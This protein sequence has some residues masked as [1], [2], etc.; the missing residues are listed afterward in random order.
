MSNRIDFYQGVEQS[1]AIPAA[2]GAVVFINGAAS[3][4][5]EVIEIIT[6][7]APEFGSARFRFDKAGYE[8]QHINQFAQLA[9]VGSCVE[10]F[11][12]YDKGEGTSIP[13][14]RRIFIGQIE[15]AEATLEENEDL[16]E[17]VARDYSA[18][19][20]R[21]T[22]SG[23]RIN[24]GDT[25]FEAKGVSLVFNEDGNGNASRFSVLRNGN[26]SRLFSA[27]SNSVYWTCSGVVEYL[28]AEYV[29]P[30]AISMPPVEL[31]DTV[32]DGAVCDE[33]DVEGD[34]LMDALVKV[35]DISGVSFKFVPCENIGSSRISFYR[36][37]QCRRVELDMQIEGEVLNLSKTQIGKIKRASSF[38]PIT[39]R[40]YA[41]GEKK[42]FE[43][44]FELV[45]AWDP[46]L[47]GRTQ[48]EYETSHIDY[49]QVV[50]VYRKWCLNETGEYSTAPYNRGDMFDLS[51][52]DGK[53][54]FLGGQRRFTDSISTDQDGNSYGVYGEI[55]Y[56]SGAN[57]EKFDGACATLSNECG[58][59][60]SGNSLGTD[61]Y[62][63]AIAGLLRFRVTAAVVSDGR[64]MASVAD[65]PVGSVVEVCDYLVNAGGLF[66][67]RKV[68]GGS[69]FY[70][71]RGG[72]D[73]SEK[74]IGALRKSANRVVNTIET[75]DIETPFVRTTIS[76][77]D[78]VVSGT[79]GRDA[80]G[81]IRDG[82]S[83]FWVDRVVMN[84]KRQTTQLKIL[85]KRQFDV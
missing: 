49:P 10:V 11:E 2:T 18:K 25:G 50:D 71:D 60:V 3:E 51:R 70:P 55:S 59:T 68:C 32:M 76:V 15:S 57:W 61:F 36:V 6:D 83:V 62:N 20:E 22:V 84:F 75:I 52:L 58:L 27:D 47:E 16:V 77:G 37:G 63:A 8:A 35:C 45:G 17:I 43:S 1:L 31:I 44:T 14:K 41:M 4:F 46:A 13:E 73:D 21:I 72:I 65:G 38:W 67:Y 5:F 39:H 85:R 19:M 66:E 53:A 42:I 74:L 30:G 12:V 56:N 69:I 26:K 48:A 64:L 40:Y 80:I 9:T 79:D 23:R 7:S 28:F 82:R 33:L 78:R 24:R 54:I 34:S 29:L 81:S